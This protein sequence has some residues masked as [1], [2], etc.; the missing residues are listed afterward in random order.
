M[1]QGVWQEGGTGYISQE[2]TVLVFF[3]FG[4]VIGCGFLLGSK[5]RLD[6]F[7]K[8]SPVTKPLHV[9]ELHLISHLL[10]NGSMAVMSASSSL[11]L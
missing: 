3:L 8:V 10:K 5:Q 4:L 1:T 6:C 9:L 11:G 2:S 7:V